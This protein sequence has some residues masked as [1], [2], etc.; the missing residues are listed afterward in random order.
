MLS[1]KQKRMR[2]VVARFQE[3]VRTYS[4][5]ACYD[6]YRDST[7]IDDMLYGIG[8]AI[9]PNKHQAAPG[10]DAFKT[11]LRKRLSLGMAKVRR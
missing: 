2:A 9:E 1:R 3:Y 6:Q 5:Q 10:Y 7:F 11:K 8:I 4:D